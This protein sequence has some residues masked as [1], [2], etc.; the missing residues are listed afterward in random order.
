[1]LLDPQLRAAAL[2]QLKLWL[3]KGALLGGGSS[4][5]AD[6]LLVRRAGG[7]RRGARRLGVRGVVVAALA[8]ARPALAWPRAARL[9][10]WER[11][12][13]ACST[14]RVSE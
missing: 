6:S 11:L 14:A 12:L 13:S 4:R 5:G 8:G 1:M 2:T 7:E 9:G 3:E 10:R